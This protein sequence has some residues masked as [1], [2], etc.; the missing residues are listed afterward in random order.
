L[1]RLD[2]RTDLDVH[3]NDQTGYRRTERRR[4]FRP[5]ALFDSWRIARYA[6]RGPDLVAP[7]AERQRVAAARGVSSPRRAARYRQASAAP[8]AFQSAPRD[9]QRHRFHP[10]VRGRRP[11]RPR[12][13]V[14]LQTTLLHA[15]SGTSSQT[16]STCA[17]CGTCRTT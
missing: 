10:R 4:P 5:A 14:R 17:V 7:A 6:R 3:P 9:S 11:A 2:T 13:C 16:V 12:R 1:P 15:T 8:R